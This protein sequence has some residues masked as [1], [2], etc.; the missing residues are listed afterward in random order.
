MKKILQVLFVLM[1]ALMPMAGVSA[2]ADEVFCG[3]LAAAD[4]ELLRANRVADAGLTS[5]TYELHITMS[6]VQPPGAQPQILAISSAG[7]LSDDKADLDAMTDEILNTTIGEVL[8]LL[9]NPDALIERVVGYVE[10]LA[11][12]PTAEVHVEVLPEGIE[13]GVQNLSADFKMTD[14]VIYV[15]SPLLAAVN[16]PPDTW[17]S[18]DLVEVTNKLVAQLQD[19]AFVEGMMSG[20]VTALPAP[21]TPVMGGEGPPAAEGQAMFAKIAAIANAPYWDEMAS[22]EFTAKFVTLTRLA[23]TEVDG[24][25][26]AVFEDRVDMATL[27][28]SDPFQQAFSDLFDLFAQG[29]SPE[30]LEALKPV[31]LDMIAGMETGGT[32]TI[33][34]E[35]H[36]TYSVDVSWSMT[37][38][39]KAFV[40]AVA[41]EGEATASPEQPLAVQTQTFEFHQEIRD[42]NQPVVVTPPP[43]EKVISL[44]AT[45]LGWSPAS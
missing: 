2:Q 10:R 31:I 45:I 18:L 32:R 25:P 14:G 35:D 8:K 29:A 9:D 43:A 6:V 40:S 12:A 16:M 19:P 30:E 24:V 21:A 28:A 33:G 17:V 27:V 13:E 5:L 22:P 41:P 26:V 7:A 44:L 36:F 1:I 37:L 3:T 15:T 4:C 38:D 42:H 11:K 34:L 20:G 39:P 23:D